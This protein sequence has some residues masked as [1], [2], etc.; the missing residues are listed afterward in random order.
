MSLQMLMLLKEQVAGTSV[1]LYPFVYVKSSDL[2]NYLFFVGIISNTV[3]IL[4]SNSTWLVN[5]IIFL[6][7]S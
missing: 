5:L 3:F 6:Q 2:F 4:I 1:G 7:W